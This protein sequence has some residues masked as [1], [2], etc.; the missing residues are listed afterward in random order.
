MFKKILIT[1]IVY[2]NFINYVYSDIIKDFQIN[3]N[4]R[5]SK[6]TIILFT[7]YKVQQNINSDDLNNILK[8]L[9][10]TT[11]FEDVSINFENNILLINVKENPLIQSII[12]EGIKKQSLVERLKDILILKEKSSFVESKIKSDQNRIINS[13]RVN[14]Y[15]FSEVTTSFKKNKNNTVDIVYN[16]SLGNKALIKNI[17]FIGNKVFKDNK[18]RKVIVSEEDRFWKFITQKKNVDAK[19]FDL[20]ESLLKSFYKNNGYYNVKINS[21]FAQIIEDKYFEVVFNIDAGNKYYFNNLTLDI[22]LDY[23]KEDFQELQKVLKDLSSKPYSLNRIEDILD[24]IDLVA[25][26]KNYEFVSA[27]Y[28][29]TIIDNNKIN[30]NIKI[31][32]AEKFYIEKINIF[33]NNITSERVVRNQL[34]SDEGDPFN[35]ILFNK[36]INNI[37]ARGLF[38]K[39][40]TKVITDND[41]MTKL[42]DINLEEKPT[43]EIFAGAGTG[44]SGSSLSFGISENN[45]LGE[46][47]KLGTDVEITTKSFEGRLFIN[48]PNYKNSNKSFNRSFERSEDDKLSKF[49][50]KTSKTG[51]SLGTYYEQYKDIYFSPNLSNYYETIETNNLASSAKRK[52]DGDYLDLLLDYSI[53]LNKLNQNFNP[54][55]GFLFIFSQEL[56]LYSEEYTLINKINY[57]KYFQTENNL[58]YSLSFFSASANSLSNDDARITKRIF[59]PARRLRGFE[60]GKIGPKDGSDY[61][62]GNYGS[63]FNV[64]STLPD[65]F[66]DL[67]NVDFSVFFDAANVWGVDYSSSI[68]ENSKIR[69]STGVALD[70]F[71]PIGPL[72]LSYSFPISKTST[73]TTEKIRFNIG[74]TF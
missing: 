39:V 42:I 38:K 71:T 49:G 14:G 25:L 54:S 57:T 56:P 28:D 66:T 67:E 11:F 46:G 36:S 47:V 48:E 68:D 18:L 59:I 58:I 1:L 51:F 20:D 3:G 10:G 29:E 74:T 73:D 31:K 50:Y 4:D 65:L 62:G 72:S 15:Y 41:K 43:G 17:K 16:V 45:Y 35:E 26:N 61:I 13:L 63:S 34:I 12:F 40:N 9:Y 27:S 30:L 53:N 19:R 55:D 64:S 32:D 23:K 21:T 33:G 37:K 60:P 5:I 6:E 24:E 7:G 2:F 22:P 69:S 44:T 70:W 52:Q 8:N